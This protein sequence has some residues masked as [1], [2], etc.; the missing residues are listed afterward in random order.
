MEVPIFA[1]YSA[2][3]ENCAFCIENC[4]FVFRR[5]SYVL[6][7]GDVGAKVIHSNNKLNKRKFGW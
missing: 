1:T 6:G 3:F 7:C 2:V 4:A 5:R